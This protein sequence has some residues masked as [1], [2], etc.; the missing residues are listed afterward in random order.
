MSM[1]TAQQVGLSNVAE[2][3]RLYFYTNCEVQCDKIQC[4]CLYILHVVDTLF[5]IHLFCCTRK[6]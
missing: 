1:V 4:N 3:P 5:T 6:L 2:L